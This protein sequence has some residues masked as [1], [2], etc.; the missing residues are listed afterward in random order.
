MKDIILS[1]IDISD[2][3]YELLLS[4]ATRHHVPKGQLLFRP[5]KPNLKYL[6]LEKGLLRGYKV[7]DGKEYTHHFYF[8]KWFATDYKS[9]LT[10]RASDLFI[11]TLT[12]VDYYAFNKKDLLHLFSTQHAFEKLGRIIAEEAFLQTVEKLSDMQVLNL[13]ERYKNLLNKNP[14]LFQKVPQ[15][16]IASYLGVAEQSLSRIKNNL[17]S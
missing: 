17:I 13:E 6:F 1:H 4:V 3:Q 11:E 10:E 16:H 14:E 9:Y 8:P 2:H 7:I 15:R 5:S 12:D